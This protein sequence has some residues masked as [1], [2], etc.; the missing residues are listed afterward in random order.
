MRGSALR[1]TPWMNF[2]FCRTRAG[3]ANAFEY[4]KSGLEWNQSQGAG[5]P[6]L[7]RK[8]A[9]VEIMIHGNGN[10][11][12]GMQAYIG[13]VDNPYFA[14]SGEDGSCR[15]GKPAARPLQRRDMARKTETLEQQE[16][17]APHSNTKADV[18]FKGTN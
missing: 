12:G 3:L 9:R 11:H 16:T 4:V 1:K 6:P 14:V 2:W 18:T 15:M 8:F 13:V 7:T 5:E 10:V 17:V